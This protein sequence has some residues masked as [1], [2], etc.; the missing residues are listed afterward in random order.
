VC[1]GGALELDPIVKV[2]DLQQLK[3]VLV[4]DRI[5]EVFLALILQFLNKGGALKQQS[6]RT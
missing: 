3:A 6:L 4:A 2:G 5:G 1:Q